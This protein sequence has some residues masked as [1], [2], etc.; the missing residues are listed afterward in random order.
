VYNFFKDQLAFGEED[1]N[2]IVSNTSKVYSEHL[3]KI[4]LGDSN[5][6]DIL[7]VI[8]KTVKSDNVPVKLVSHAIVLGYTC[9]WLWE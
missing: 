8:V 9:R 4:L 7:K 6:K 1:W 2:I 3:I 5:R